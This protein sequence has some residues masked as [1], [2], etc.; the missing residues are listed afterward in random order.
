MPDLIAAQ[1]PLDWHEARLILEELAAELEAAEHDGT[2]PDVLAIPRVWVQPDGRAIL[3]DA[4]LDPYP[5]THFPID[6]PDPPRRSL[7]LLRRA[8]T[9]LLGGRAT[10][11]RSDPAPVGSPVP[12]HVIDALDRLTG[13]A[14]PYTSVSEFRADLD[15]TRERP[16]E[17]TP[18]L[19]FAHAGYTFVSIALKTWLIPTIVVVYTYAVSALA[20]EPIADIPERVF[21]RIILF[22][23]FLWVLVSMT[24]RAG[25][26]GLIWGVTIVRS[27]GRHAS[28]LRL[29]WREALIW[30]PL[31][32][33]DYLFDEVPIH[34]RFAWYREWGTLSYALIAPFL[35]LAP[36][37]LSR[38]IYLNDRLARTAVVPR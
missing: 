38:G 31:F 13:F 8:A 34:G 4:P 5:E 10:A 33:V 7:E 17:L 25:V 32:A 22:Q 26:G 14:A 1:G 28:R 24:L 23:S 36:A 15:A 27:D 37:A 19:R 20:G 2:L 11:D 21:D 16:A 30:L 18:T 9:C 6:D 35:F 3:I 29:G 12:G